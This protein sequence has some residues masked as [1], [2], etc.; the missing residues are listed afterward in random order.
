MAPRRAPTIK[1]N[2]VGLSN[3]IFSHRKNSIIFNELTAFHSKKKSERTREDSQVLSPYGQRAPP[4]RTPRSLP[5][6]SHR[7]R[8]RQILNGFQKFFNADRNRMIAKTT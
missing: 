8:M 3:T 4:P 7:E 2:E 5:Y 1:R 6:L